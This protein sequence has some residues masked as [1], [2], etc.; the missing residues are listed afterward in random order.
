MLSRVIKRVRASVNA[1]AP[2]VF[3]RTMG[4]LGRARPAEMLDGGY[5]RYATFELLA[6]EIRSRKVAGVCAE[7]GVF[8]GDFAKVI[9]WAFPERALYLFDTFEGFHSAD[10]DVEKL[11][12][13]RTKFN[14]FSAT[15]ESFVL[16]RMPHPR[17]VLIRKGL[18]PTTAAGL[19]TTFCF[20]SL[21]ADLYAPIHAGLQYFWPRLNSGGYIMVHD[22]N[23][24]SYPGVRE[25]V[26]EF[27]GATAVSFVPI[28]DGFG[29][30]VLA[31]A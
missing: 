25:A 2:I 3:D 16:G 30:V 13:L 1:R 8:Q 10:V 11:R 17:N 31:K 18:F 15:G 19:E 21:D 29:S 4:A 23:N 27:C 26:W 12:G 24:S 7:L 6:H 20:V 22:Y 28:P 5:I 9:N 14:D